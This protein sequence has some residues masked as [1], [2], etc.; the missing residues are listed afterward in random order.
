LIYWIKIKYIYSKLKGWIHPIDDEIAFVKG[1]DVE[2]LYNIKYK[3]D[4]RKKPR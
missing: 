2:S 1:L 4:M 3:Q